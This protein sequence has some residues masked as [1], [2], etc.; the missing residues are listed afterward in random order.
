MSP[1]GREEE[2]RGDVRVTEESRER[3]ERERMKER[4]KE[5][6]KDGGG[7]GGRSIDHLPAIIS[8]RVP[9]KLEHTVDSTAQ[10]STAQHSTAQHSTA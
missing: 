9:G 1:F 10:Q 6:E 8:R 3:E 7:R 2:G 5:V 4:E